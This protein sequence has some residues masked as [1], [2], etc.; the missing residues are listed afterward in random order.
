[1]STPLKRSK[2]VKLQACS[3]TR[4]NLRYNMRLAGDIL[5]GLLIEMKANISYFNDHTDK[6][7]TEREI[8]CY[9]TGQGR[10][11]RR[12]GS[13]RRP[14]LLPLSFHNLGENYTK[15]PLFFQNL[16]AAKI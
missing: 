15:F 16:N 2:T 8:F 5:T 1:M 6:N 7:Y 11:C 14:V 4:V 9:L 13:T 12:A 3:L 10:V